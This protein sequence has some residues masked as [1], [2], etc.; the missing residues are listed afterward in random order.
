MS[1][2]M[3]AMH[4]HPHAITH[5]P[6]LGLSAGRVQ[7]AGLKLLVDRE[8]E[9]MLFRPAQYAGTLVA[10]IV[11]TCP[12]VVVVVVRRNREDV[13]TRIGVCVGIV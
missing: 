1:L 8:R 5:T 7:S 6:H 10:W 3:P 4:A 11:D 2:D 12:V 9:R 13:Y